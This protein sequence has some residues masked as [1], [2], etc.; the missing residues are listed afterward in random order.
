MTFSKL[1]LEVFMKTVTNVLHAFVTQLT[2]LAVGANSFGKP[3]AAARRFEL[4]ATRFK[5]AFDVPW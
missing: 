4:A 2:D 3:A 5:M 1:L